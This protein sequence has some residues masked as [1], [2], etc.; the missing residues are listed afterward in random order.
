MFYKHLCLVPSEWDQYPS[1]FM[2]LVL[3][4]EISSYYHKNK[5]ILGADISIDETTA[6][7]QACN[8]QLWF[9]NTL[10]QFSYFIVNSKAMLII[11][12]PYCFFFFQ[13]TV[14]PV[15]LKILI[16]PKVHFHNVY[17]HLELRKAS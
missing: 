11:N 9:K 3:H 16:N 14:L 1:E 6:K 15:H 17:L 13:K 5:K 12:A 7:L 2:G 4:R 8:N 10:V